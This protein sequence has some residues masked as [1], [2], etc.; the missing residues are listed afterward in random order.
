LGFSSPKEGNRYRRSS[1]RMLPVMTLPYV[2]GHDIAVVTHKT[3]RRNR[4][5][6]E[7]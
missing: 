2:T 4:R 3:G 6:K 1:L 7:S 5:W